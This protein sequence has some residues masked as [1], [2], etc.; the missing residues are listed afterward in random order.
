MVR[1]TFS[2]VRRKNAHLIDIK[3]K[4]H[5]VV[6]THICL[7]SVVRVTLKRLIFLSVFIGM[8]APSPLT[9]DA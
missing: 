6:C 8:V 4:N 7:C 1:N 9:V 5:F 3:K 2:L